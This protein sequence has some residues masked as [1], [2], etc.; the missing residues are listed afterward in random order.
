MTAT[1]FF[2][3]EHIWL[4]VAPALRE[5]GIACLSAQEAGRRGL[6]DEVQLAWCRDQ[7]MA[8]ASFDT[9]YLGLSALTPGHA[10]IAWCRAR[11][12]AIGPF[13]DRLARLAHD[14]SAEEMRDWIEYL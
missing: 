13:I 11:K 14:R 9:D 4:P 7:G 1:S 10:G 5:L 3:D 8:L 2:L 6:P 12:Y